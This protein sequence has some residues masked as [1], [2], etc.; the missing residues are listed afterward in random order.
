MAQAALAPAL[1]EIHQKFE[2]AF[3][4]GDL[5]A[6]LALYE[7]EAVFVGM[8]GEI[9]RGHNE[10]RSAYEPLF[11]AKAQ[12]RLETVGIIESTNGLVLMHGRWKL[13]GTAE[14]GS[15]VS[16]EGTSAEV[17]RRQADGSWRYTI[18]NPFVP[19]TSA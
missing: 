14:D 5:N 9:L 11:N 4:A 12:I 17:L 7:P 18:D 16:H 19:L 6:L 2:T 10:I 1:Q 13:I 3:N 8:G 15:P